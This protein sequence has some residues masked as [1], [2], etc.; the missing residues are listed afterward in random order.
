MSGADLLMRLRATGLT[1]AV[2]GD[3]LTVRPRQLLTDE[4]RAAIR[5]HKRDLLAELPRYRWLIVEPD[6][7]RREICTLPEMT[8]GELAPC[9]PG[10]RLI[11]LPDSAAE[12][13]ASLSPTTH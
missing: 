12:A 5:A 7:T 8:V 11:P 1:V 3:A 10:A 6:G 9:Y 4:L 13:A 2:D